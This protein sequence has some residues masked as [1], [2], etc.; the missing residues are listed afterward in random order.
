M[1]LA[2]RQ[3]ETYQTAPFAIIEKDK[4]A[5][6]LHGVNSIAAENGLSAGMALTDARGVLPDLLTKERTPLREETALRG[7]QRWAQ[8]YSPWGAVD[9]EDGLVLD[10]TGC[11]HL[12]GGEAEMMKRLQQQLHDFNMEHCIC[13]ADTKGAAQIGARFGGRDV[14]I[15]P[16]GRNRAF[17]EP[18]SISALGPDSMALRRLGLKTLGDVASLPRADLTKRFG[19]D[20]TL[21]LEEALGAR[22]VPVSPTLPER[23][24]AARMSFPEPIGM[25]SDI[26]EAITR[27]LRSICEKLRE[28][29]RG[30]KTFALYLFGTDGTVQDITIGMARASSDPISAFRQFTPFLDKVDV[31]FGLDAIRG[32][33]P[34][35]E[36]T[37]AH[38]VETSFKDHPDQ[39]S[40]DHK[41]ADLVGRLGNRLGFDRITVAQAEDRHLPEAAVSHIPFVQA[42]KRRPWPPPHP[43]VSAH[44][45][46]ICRPLSIHPI[47]E[48]RPPTRFS[49]RGETVD[50][51]AAHGPHRLGGEWWESQAN[52][53]Q[54][55]DYWIA[56]SE[57][58]QRLW[59]RCDLDKGEQRHWSVAGLLP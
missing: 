45:I 53:R 32:T 7:L 25:R 14:L 21:R 52:R 13:V 30:A 15:M 33:V 37:M 49:W 4:S 23:I 50:V 57:K 20:L 5:L 29:G 51:A 56:Q 2:Q 39:H 22:A 26:D 31:G 9:G 16:P 58:G 59:L 6:R 55:R 40:L 12:F 8:Q 48:A 54:S 42:R 38:Q 34:T 3:C 43:P 10:I 36:A 44:P 17:L 11:A 1:N 35:H 46:R 18:L 47:I 41:V 27:I 19:I 28:N 24:Y